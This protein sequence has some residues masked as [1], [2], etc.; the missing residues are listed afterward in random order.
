M[1]IDSQ[2]CFS[3]WLFH[4]PVELWKHWQSLV[5]FNKVVLLWGWSQSSCSYQKACYALCGF[6]AIDSSFGIQLVP[7]LTLAL[8]PYHLPP[9]CPLICSTH[10]IL[11][12]VWKKT[13]KPANPNSRYLHDYL[14][15]AMALLCFSCKFLCGCCQAQENYVAMNIS[16]WYF[17]NI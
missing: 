1:A 10:D 9:T 3:R 13:E 2:V 15:V 8:H 11:C 16:N 17:S 4:G 7:L 14:L 6:V 5:G 12:H